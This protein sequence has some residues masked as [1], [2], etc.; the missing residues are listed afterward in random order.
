MTT[1]RTTTTDPRL[2]LSVVGGKWT[3]IYRGAPLCANTTEAGA[4]AVYHAN[5]KAPEDHSEPPVWDGDLGAFRAPT[6]AFTPPAYLP[7]VLDSRGGLT[8]VSARGQNKG[9]TLWRP[10]S[11]LRSGVA[12]HLV[13]AEAGRF[14]QTRENVTWAD[15]KVAGYAHLVRVYFCEL[16]G[17]RVK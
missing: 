5:A 2:Y 11:V 10:A 8:M 15:Y 7:S 13:K 6:V 1:T 16:T 14:Y 12:G 3:V 4:R 9:G 17:E